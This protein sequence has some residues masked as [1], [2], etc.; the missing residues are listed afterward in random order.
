MPAAV[1]FENVV[2][3]LDSPARYADL[4]HLD[5]AC[6]AG[7]RRRKT[8]KGSRGLLGLATAQASAGRTPCLWCAHD[9][10]LAAAAHEGPDGP[11]WH[12]LA[13]EF[14]FHDGSVL[15]P[16]CAALRRY[17]AGAGA[18][19][20]TNRGRVA[21]LLP[22]DG[23]ILDQQWLLLIRMK[24]KVRCA[25]ASTLPVPTAEVWDTA[26]E[27]VTQEI[28]LSDALVLAAAMHAAPTRT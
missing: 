2:G 26:A 16:R 18:L 13:C 7:S 22:G 19:A 1:I 12:F 4:W 15:C 10:V 5:R 20:G 14:P 3:Y 9:T 6:Q 28:R 11:G 8:I 17:G 24:L 25:P 21:L 27:L 23:D